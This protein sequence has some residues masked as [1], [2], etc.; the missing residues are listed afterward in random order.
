MLNY[1]KDIDG[2]RAIA[3]LMVVFLH[4]NLGSSI[5][6]GGFVGVDVFFVISGFLITSLI[7]RNLARDKFTFKGFYLHR[8][9]RLMP[10]LLFTII[11]AFVGSWLIMVPEDFA[12]FMSSVFYTP[13]AGSNILFFVESLNYFGRDAEIFPL[14][15]TWSLAVEEQF[16]I[17]IPFFLIFSYKCIAKPKCLNMVLIALLVFGLALSV[18]LAENYKVFAYFLL[19]ARFFELFIGVVLAINYTKLPVSKNKYFNHSLSIIGFLLI[20]IPAFVVTDSTVFPGF[21]ALF[22]CLGTAIV[23]Y[24]GKCEELPVINRI[25]SFKPI[26]FLGMISYSL[27]LL[28]WPVLAIMAYLYI[29][30]SNIEML[31]IVIIMV[32]ASALMWK[33]IEQPFRFKYKWGFMKTLFVFFIIPVIV[34]GMLFMLNR[35]N[36]LKP[37]VSYNK[38]LSEV[39]ENSKDKDNYCFSYLRYNDKMPDMKK[40]KININ[41]SSLKN[42]LVIGDSHANSMLGFME[43]LMGSEFNIFNLSGGKQFYYGNLDLETLNSYKNR[44]KKNSNVYKIW[45]KNKY[46]NKH[47]TEKKY[48][49]IVVGGFYKNYIDREMLT[50]SEFQKIMDEAIVFLKQYTNNVVV[51]KDVPAG[52][53]LFSSPPACYSQK[54]TRDSSINCTFS[55]D[56]IYKRERYVDE[57]LN[58]LEVKHQDVKFITP[59]NILCD[60]TECKTRINNVILYKDKSHITYLGA[61]KLGEIYLEQYGNPFK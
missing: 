4:A 57:I 1:R 2:L 58:V 54:I 53:I 43:S 56:L 52:E 27:Y 25:L 33:F 21:A 41:D 45:E 19:P 15:H 55:Y 29:V 12:F 42:V 14:L 10:A 16:Y 46:I 22:V 44:T 40:C 60:K 7:Q 6:T 59:K 61:K 51:I 18:Y 32:A 34:C 8:I 35:Q 30:P 36:I 11:L 39:L 26:V 23:I 48:D 31:G 37:R 5:M 49:Y 3:V 50:Y 9:R 38:E 24:L 47:I 20:V 28:H 17:I 13:I